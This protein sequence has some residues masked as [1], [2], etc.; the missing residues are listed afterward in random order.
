[1]YKYIFYTKLINYLL[2]YKS[3][4]RDSI[5]KIIKKLNY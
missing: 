3:S 1:M 4:K 5:L 2:G